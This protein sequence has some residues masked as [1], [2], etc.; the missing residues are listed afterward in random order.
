[1][2]R[3]LQYKNQ[4]YEKRIK[5]TEKLINLFFIGYLIILLFVA[6]LLCNALAIT[7]NG[8]KMPVQLKY[9]SHIDGS[10]VYS[11]SNDKHFGFKDKEDINYYYLSDIIHIESLHT[12]Y[13]IGDILMYVGI[14]LI[15]IHYIII[16]IYMFQIKKIDKMIKG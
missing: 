5:K 9:L 16:G 8:G 6:G 15:V 11:Y 12:V 7:N 1:M 13:S 2:I 10:S 14:F 4:L 3:K